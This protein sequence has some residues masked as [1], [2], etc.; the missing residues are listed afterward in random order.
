MPPTKC[1]SSH[2]ASGEDVR[3][4]LVVPVRMTE[5]PSVRPATAKS[6][7]KVTIKDGT[8][9]RITNTPLMKPTSAPRASAAMTPTEVGAWKCPDTIAMVMDPAGIIDPIEM[10]SSPAIISSPIGIATIPSE[11]ATL[12]QLAAPVTDTKLS[13]PKMAKKTKTA[14]R[15]R[16][17]P[18]SGRR[19]RLPNARR[20]G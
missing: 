3:A 5:R 15:P 12:S 17:E 10:S 9:V 19:K 20:R 6:V 13:P 14:T 11:A 16:N 18:V 8:A 4:T 2:F 7:P 1:P